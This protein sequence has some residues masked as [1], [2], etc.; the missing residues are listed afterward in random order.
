VRCGEPVAG[1]VIAA[2]AF[3]LTRGQDF[4]IRKTGTRDPAGCKVRGIASR[5]TTEGNGATRRASHG[6][7]PQLPIAAPILSRSAY[8][9]VAARC[10]ARMPLARRNSQVGATKT[11][12]PC[13]EAIGRGFEIPHSTLDVSFGSPTKKTAAEIAVT[14]RKPVL[15]ACEVSGVAGVVRSSPRNVIFTATETLFSR[16]RSCRTQPGTDG[17]NPSLSSAESATRLYPQSF[18]QPARWD[19]ARCGVGTAGRRRKVS[20]HRM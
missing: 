20:R 19:Y 7:V 10:S 6:G 16:H 17:S 11:T 12:D 14:A 3:R 13:S 8:C 5:R 4:R 1:A 2:K 18:S 15:R 9:Y